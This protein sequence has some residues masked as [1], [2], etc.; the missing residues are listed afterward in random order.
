MALRLPKSLSPEEFK[1]LIRCVPKADKEA[2]VA[3]LLAYG[4]GLRISEVVGLR[5]DNLR[6]NSMEIL[7]GKGKKDR[8]VPKP[9]GWKDWMTK[10]LPISKTPRSLQRNFKSAA[11]K[12]KLNPKYTFHSLRHGFAT[13]LLENGVPLN[14][15]QLLLGHSSLATTSLYTKARPIDAIKSYE[16][17]F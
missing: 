1:S 12:A 8:I 13:R 11:K 4:S 14:Q 9:K 2:R 3:F 5:S 17:L 10:L 16:E 7:S 15:I 6:E